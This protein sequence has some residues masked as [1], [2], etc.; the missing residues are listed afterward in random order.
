MAYNHMIT[1][2]SND[3]L[4]VAMLLTKLQMV[5]AAWFTRILAAIFA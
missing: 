3:S 4:G 2:A 1:S 5:V